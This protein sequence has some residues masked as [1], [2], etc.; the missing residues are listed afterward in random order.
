[1]STLDETLLVRAFLQL[2]RDL[3][4]VQ[5]LT[6]EQLADSARVHRTTIGLLESAQR[7]PTLQVAGQIATALGYKLSELVQKAELIAEGELREDKVVE[8]ASSRKAKVMC[9]RDGKAL[10]KL[11]GLKN[12]SILAAIDTCYRTLDV[13]DEQLVSH[14]SCPISQLIE[15][16]NLSSMVGNLLG[17]GLADASEG[18]YV[19]NRPHCFPDLLPKDPHKIELE[20]KIALEKNRPKGHLPKPGTYITFRYVLGDNKGRFIRGKNNRGDT[21]WI[22]EVRVGVLKAEDFAIS[23]TDGDSGK[24]ANIK[25]DVFD[26]MPLV[27]RDD[28]L[29]PYARKHR[30]SPA[31]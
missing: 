10:E 15:L 25:N 11:T 6:H 3:R 9:L 20:I 24:T 13:I 21:V 18:L 30:E 7:S 16:A 2:M 27:Y 28:E 23:S 1:M 8:A 12:G 14:G 19:R 31:S 26:A 4:K 22:W 17:A 5:N 29:I